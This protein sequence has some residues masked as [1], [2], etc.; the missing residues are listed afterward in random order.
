MFDFMEAIFNL[1]DFYPCQVSVVPDIHLPQVELSLPFKKNSPYLTVINYQLNLNLQNG[2]VNKIL[3][4]YF[5]FNKIASQNIQCEDPKTS[6]G[7]AN[8]FLPFTILAISMFFCL[9]IMVFEKCF[10]KEFNIPKKEK[11]QRDTKSKEDLMV[12]WNI[13]MDESTNEEL[14]F[15]L[16]CDFFSK[17]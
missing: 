10:C 15:N 3:N 6:L 2:K 13:I 12:I 5:S 11:F 4:K 7:F 14:K 1:P 17:L 16:V 9:I 8:T